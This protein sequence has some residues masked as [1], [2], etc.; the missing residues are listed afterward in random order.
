MGS[1]VG[2]FNK[3]LRLR[4]QLIRKYYQQYDVNFST[5]NIINQ[6]WISPFHSN[7]SRR[8]QP[9]AKP[10]Q[11]KP[12]PKRIE[13]LYWMILM[14][15]ENNLEPSYNSLQGSSLL[16]KL[17]SIDFKFKRIGEFTIR[18]NSVENDDRKFCQVFFS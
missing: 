9:L 8:Q 5:R 4:E 3:L 15:R 18:L 10:Y 17:T 14:N 11:K 13:K 6:S 7:S 2:T 16:F 12:T 1:L